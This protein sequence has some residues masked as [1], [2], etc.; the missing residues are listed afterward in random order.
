MNSFLK[1]LLTATAVIPLFGPGGESIEWR[2]RFKTNYK[3]RTRLLHSASRRVLSFGP[4]ER[5]RIRDANLNVRA[6]NLCLV[7]LLVINTSG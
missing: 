3:K 1:A 7:A 6:K 2:Q 4:I 5:H